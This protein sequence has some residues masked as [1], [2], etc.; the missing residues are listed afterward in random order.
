MRSRGDLPDPA[1][2]R[3]ERVDVARI[4]VACRVLGK[5][6]LTREPAGHVSMRVDADRVLIKSRGADESGLRFAGDADVVAVDLAGRRLDGG[7]S[8]GVPKEVFLHL[9]VYLA[10]PDVRGVAHV[11]PMTPVLLTI[12]DVPL[13]PLIGAYD[14]LALRLLSRGVPV[15]PRSVLIAT[16][17]LGAQV[18]ELLGDSAACLL[19]GHGVTTTGA[20]PEEAALNAIKVN[21]MAE[22]SYR[23]HLLGTPQPTAPAD[24]AAIGEVTAEVRRGHVESAWRYYCR[25]VGETPVGP[26][27]PR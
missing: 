24:I 25:L 20:S 21:E 16:P 9:A 11:H 6:D 2:D 1:V 26:A 13:L 19:R 15:Y 7:G 17:E 4:A 27:A 14:P 5:L 8:A 22:L 18:A 3:D 10:N 12:C 23:A